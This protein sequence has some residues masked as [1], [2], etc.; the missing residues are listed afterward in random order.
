MKILNELGEEILEIN[1][2][3]G[4]KRTV[5]T[6][7]EESDYKI[8]AILHLISSEVAEAGEGFRHD[9]KANFAEELADVI[10]R[11]LDLT[12]GLGIDIDAEVRKKLEAN[13]LRGYKH[14]GKRV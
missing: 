9:D 14:G 3:N 1:A 6:D 13:R 7:W 8:L 10:I 11:T 2:A 4:W 5:P 12:A